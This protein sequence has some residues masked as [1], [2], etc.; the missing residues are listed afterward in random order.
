MRREMSSR[1]ARDQRARVFSI[2]SIYCIDGFDRVAGHWSVE[3]GRTG[4]ENIAASVGNSFPSSTW[5]TMARSS[6]STNVD[7]QGD[8]LVPSVGRFQCLGERSP[9]VGR[10]QN[11]SLQRAWSRLFEGTGPPFA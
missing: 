9:C 11:F 8:V 10:T 4:E 7:V 1:S 6:S 2:Q 3:V 5:D